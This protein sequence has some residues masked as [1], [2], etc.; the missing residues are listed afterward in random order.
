MIITSLLSAAIGF[1][2]VGDQQN[3]WLACQVSVPNADR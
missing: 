2:A 3:A 1:Q